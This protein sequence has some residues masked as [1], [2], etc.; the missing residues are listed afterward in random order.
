[1]C[2]GR[3]TRYESLPL[4]ASSR[5]ESQS[6][7]R[8]LAHALIAFVSISVQASGSDADCIVL[9]TGKSQ[10]D[11]VYSKSTAFQVINLPLSSSH[12]NFCAIYCL[13]AI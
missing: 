8:A 11:I 5:F 10:P 1:M 9:L 4:L 13:P 12:E 3:R 6:I 7:A 2:W